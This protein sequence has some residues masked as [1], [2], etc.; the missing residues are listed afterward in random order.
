[1]AYSFYTRA[2]GGRPCGACD[3]THPRDNE[4]QRVFF[5]VQSNT[6]TTIK[7]PPRPISLHLATTRTSNRSSANNFTHTLTLKEEQYRMVGK[8]IKYRRPTYT[9]STRTYTRYTHGLNLLKKKRSNRR[10]PTPDYWS[11]G[12]PLLRCFWVE[13]M[14]G[15]PLAPQGSQ[16]TRFVEAT[17]TGET[18]RS[19][20]SINNSNTEAPRHK[21]K[22]QHLDM[23]DGHGRTIR[24]RRR[25]RFHA[26]HGHGNSIF[27]LFWR[28]RAQ[29]RRELTPSEHQLRN[30]AA[31]TRPTIK[32][33]TDY[34]FSSR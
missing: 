19:I 15:V 25:V 13:R 24:S 27:F 7:G 8:R 30:M 17:V 3:T 31:E 9:H 26:A 29:R 16:W 28:A 34:S 5:R 14:D 18:L 22:Q 33:R 2:L 12:S 1:M 20:R 21:N 23:K 32:R 6:M 4:T 10:S 11:N